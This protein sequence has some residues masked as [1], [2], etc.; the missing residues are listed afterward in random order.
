MKLFS[1]YIILEGNKRNRRRNIKTQKMDDNDKAKRKP[2]IINILKFLYL[3]DIIDK[4]DNEDIK[5][6]YKTLYNDCIGQ[7][8]NIK[9]INTT[10]KNDK[11]KIP[12]ITSDFDVSSYFNISDITKGGIM[13]DFVKNY[14]TSLKKQIT[15][16]YKSIENINTHKANESLHIYEDVSAASETTKQQYK[17]DNNKS[18]DNKNDDNSILDKLKQQLET[19]KDVKFDDDNNLYTICKNLI[20]NFE[21][22]VKNIEDTE[23]KKKQIEDY[24]KKFKKYIEEIQKLNNSLQKDKPSE[25]KPT[26]KSKEVNKEVKQ[27]EQKVINSKYLRDL[28][29]GLINDSTR[30][31]F[32]ELFYS[33]A[34]D[35]IKENPDNEQYLGLTIITIAA[36]ILKQNEVDKQTIETYLT[37]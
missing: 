19:I 29:D 35:K 36:S 9:N 23:E 20:D 7:L 17:Q 21:T 2:Y 37:I 6:K 18:E 11:F 5:D 34:D 26:N 16:F 13:D 8:S 27:T 14:D 25:E 15:D 3:K 30:K 12:E 22:F 24:N 1:E 4:I 32:E 33:L 28:T 10:D 31:K